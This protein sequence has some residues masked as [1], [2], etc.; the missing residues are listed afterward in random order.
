LRPIA[1]N[2]AKK[3]VLFQSFP[4]DFRLKRV[5]M[6]K[7]LATFQELCDEIGVHR[8]TVSRKLKPYRS[9]FK[10]NGERKRFYTRK[11]QARVKKI[12]AG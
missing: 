1:P 7:K 8:S 4:L 3:V 5:A 9:Q 10:C 2:G 11:E 12:V 6:S